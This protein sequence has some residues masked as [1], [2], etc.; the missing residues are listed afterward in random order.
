M[1]NYGLDFSGNE[2]FVKS[3]ETLHGT[4][5]Y[6]S[7]IMGIFDGWARKNK[8]NLTDMKIFHGILHKNCTRQRDFIKEYNLSRTTVNTAV[9][10]MVSKSWIVINPQDK[11]IT[12]TDEG[13]KEADKIENYFQEIV[14]KIDAK[15][16]SQANSKIHPFNV[17]ATTLIGVF[18]ESGCLL[19]SNYKVSK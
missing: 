13:K 7:F 3:I 4:Y 18:A 8:I 12:L 17:G 11:T 16:P 9:N 2:Y 10:K 19:K 6:A 1:E 5:R 15:Y 14:Q